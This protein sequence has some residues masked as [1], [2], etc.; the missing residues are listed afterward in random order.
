MEETPTPPLSRMCKGFSSLAWIEPNGKIHWMSMRYTHG[1][2]AFVYLNPDREGAAYIPDSEQSSER[3][4]QEGWIRVSSATDIDVRNIDSISQAAWDAW[5][6]IVTSC[7][8]QIQPHS[9]MTVS[10]SSKLSDYFKITVGD[11]VEKYCSRN[12]S[13][14]YWGKLMGESRK[15][16]IPGR[17]SRINEFHEIHQALEALSSLAPH[18]ANYL[19]GL[20]NAGNTKEQVLGMLGKFKGYR[21]SLPQPIFRAMEIVVP[22]FRTIED[23]EGRVLQMSEEEL[24]R[25][26]GKLLL[27]IQSGR[28]AGS[29]MGESLV[30]SIVRMTLLEDLKGF[31]ART[32]DID[33][34]ANLSDPTFEDP[35]Q[36]SLVNKPL[37]IDVKRAWAAEADHKFMDSLIKIH[38]TGGLDWEKKLRNFLNLSGKNEISTS[39]YLPGSKEFVSSWGTIGVIVKGRTTLASNDMNTVNSGY[40]GQTPPE[41][42]KKYTSSGVPKRPLS[43]RGPSAWGGGSSKY[44]LD[45]DSFDPY[46]SRRSEFIVD[47]WKPVGIIVDIIDFL[48]TVQFPSVSA[49]PNIRY[50]EVVLE[51]GLP[52]YDWEMKEIPK[53]KIEAALRGSGGR[54]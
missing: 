29:A 13:D 53:E 5:S 27:A 3:L 48:G 22:G 52:V 45:R 7:A 43:F 35:R 42:L 50:A 21:D 1:S 51:L 44:I 40:H 12:A 46:E 41:T 19:D 17:Q 6:T 8:G 38:W 20:I 10:T 36:G 54:L 4:R 16:R 30:R 37:A 2:W 24:D 9:E 23:F 15:R 14:A 26:L 31:Q 47:N 25:R 33:Y 39:G 28:L 34:M 18:I 49:E 11:F 32:K